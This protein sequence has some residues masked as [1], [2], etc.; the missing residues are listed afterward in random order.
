MHVVLQK[1]ASGTRD[2]PATAESFLS[3]WTAQAKALE[4][5]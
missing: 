5:M 3:S 2:S 1:L 4:G